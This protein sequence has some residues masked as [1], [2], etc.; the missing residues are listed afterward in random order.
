M[1]AITDSIT[2]LIKEAALSLDLPL[3]KKDEIF[4]EHPADREHGDYATNIA[5]KLFGQLSANQKDSFENP[6]QLA[7]AI[8]T[9]MNKKMNSILSKIQVAGPGFINFTLSEHFLLEELERVLTN[10]DQLAPQINQGKRVVVEYSSPNIAKPFTIGHLR[11]T[12]IG[13]A[14]ANLLEETG[15]EVL[16]DNHLGDWGTQ[17][18]KQIYAIK[19]WGD[20]KEIEQSERPVKKLVQLYVKFHQEAEKDPALE[21]KGREWFKRLEA[22]DPE[23]RRLWKKCVAWSWREFASIYQKLGVSFSQEFDNGKGLGESFFEDKMEA[24]IEELAE[25]KLLQEGINGA[26][27]VFF[28]DDKYPPAM[29]LKGDG[30]TLYHTR[31]L[32]T[33]KYRL[34]KYK[35]DLVINE[36]GMEQKLY[37]EQLIEIERLLGW[38]KPEERYHLQHGM[39]R[40]KDKK[41]STRKGNVIW[42]EDVLLEAFKRVKKVAHKRL[43]EGEMWKVAIGALKYN[44]LK[45]Q[46]TSDVIFDWDEI[47]R[48]DGNSGPYLQYTFVRCQSILEKVSQR[49]ENEA[50]GFD[51]LINIKEVKDIEKAS[52]EID[53]LRIFYKYY[54]VLKQASMQK[55]PYLVANYLYRLAQAFNVFYTRQPILKEK[56]QH[57]RQFRLALTKAT[58]TILEHGLGILNIALPAE[59]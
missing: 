35:P 4:L 17:F 25:K 19:T 54:E 51:V 7:T 12:I 41:M 13:D 1:Q 24:V 33:D 45:R 50:D 43:D 8:V 27:L 2:T 14:V 9:A 40:F 58:A 21:D 29:I 31:D 16:R 38:Y 11:S 36:V 34:D 56:N 32:A 37:F 53:L 30:T 49:L 47:V 18:G 59:M 20:E 26:K 23:A 6:R 3:S 46:A 48:L 44:D 28:S 10:S 52:C 15:A 22:G 42:L 39:F 57:S 5:L 55:A